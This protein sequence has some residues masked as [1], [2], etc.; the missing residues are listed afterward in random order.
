MNEPT[1]SIQ[2]TL[3]SGEVINTTIGKAM[4]KMAEVVDAFADGL[5]AL[6]AD[7]DIPTEAQSTNEN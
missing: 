5:D 7:R 1:K 6:T 4:Q 2:I 3:S